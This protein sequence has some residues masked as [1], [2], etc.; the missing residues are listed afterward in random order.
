LTLPQQSQSAL[1]TLDRVIKSERKIIAA[2]IAVIT[3]VAWSYLLAGAGTG[4][5]AQAMTTWRFPPSAEALFGP[6][7]WSPH[8]ALM[9]VTMWFVMMI[10]MMLPSATPMMMMYA[11]V[12]AQGQRQGQITSGRIPILPFAA[13]Y[14][15]CWLLFSVAATLLQFV[16]EI[17]GLVDGMWM[18]SQSRHLTA[19]LLVL[20]G[21][22]QFTSLKR[23]C[24]NHC[25]SPAAFLSQNWR[26]GRNGA[27]RLGVV[28]GFYCIGCCWSLMLLLF[29][30]G[31]MNLVW[32]A[33]LSIVALLEKL[34]PFGARLSKPIGVLLMAA[35]VFVAAAAQ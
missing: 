19:G 3:I 24:L 29:A 27:F 15:L 28:H 14:L 23:A 1:E 4:M 7:N 22:Y 31:V 32:I 11:R 12:Y 35:G 20:A 34:A 10:A 16:L 8:Y 30:G 6:A 5:S 26:P 9:M 33:G 18:W 17:T 2:A 25:R 13:G 21:L